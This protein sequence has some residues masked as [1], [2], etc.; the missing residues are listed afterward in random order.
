MTD[1]I[2]WTRMGSYFP[3]SGGF[4]I[5]QSN[6]T[7]SISPDDVVQGLLGDCWLLSAASA[8]AAVPARIWN[9]FDTKRYNK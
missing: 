8:V 1:N 4:S 9:M 5:F 7:A 3:S 6:L 2:T